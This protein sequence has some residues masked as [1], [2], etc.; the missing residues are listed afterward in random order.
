MAASLVG[1]IIGELPTGAVAG[2]G[3]R[4]LSGSYY[5]QTIQIWAALVMAAIL[6]A[7]L[8]GLI[9]P[10]GADHR[11][12]DGRAARV[13]GSGAVGP[14][15]GLL[16]VLADPARG[17]VGRR[18]QAGGEIAG[19]RAQRR[20]LPGVPMARSAQL[21]PFLTKLRWSVAAASISG[22]RERKSASVPRPCSASEARSAKAARRPNSSSR[23]AQASTLA[24]ACGTWSKSLKQ[25]VSTIA[26]LSKSARQ[27]S[28]CAGVTAAGSSISA[29]TVR[30]S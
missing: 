21:T 30:A 28:I 2:L 23:V 26:Q 16:R 25:T 12:G 4:M 14:G 18:G 29:A 17:L 5:G 22:R 10:G 7:G 1:A 19:G 27:R 9:G 8:V 11:A 15:E 24:K 13:N 3:A 20:A 6:A